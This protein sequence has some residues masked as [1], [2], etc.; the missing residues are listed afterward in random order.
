MPTFALPYGRTTLTCVVPERFR[1]NLLTLAPTPAAADP[2]QAVTDA[3]DRLLGAVR[4]DDFAGARTAAVA[5]N[6]KTRP[7]PHDHLLPPLLA[8]LEALGLPPE[9]ITLLIATGT[10]PPMAPDTFHTILPP[11]VLARYPVICHDCDDQAEL[12]HLG[13]TA[14]GTPVRINRRFAAADVRVVVG[15]IEPHQFQGFSGGVKSAAIGLAGRATVNHNHALMTDAQAR[16][17]QF[18]GNPARQ[19]VEE[20]GRIIHIHLALNAVLNDHKAVVHA[21]A[22]DPAAVL[23]AGIPLAQAICQVAV[24]APYDVV[25][26]SPGG[27]PKDINVYQAQKALAHAALITRPGGSVIL[28]AACPEGSGS[29]GYEQWVSGC[30]SQADVLDRFAREG[31][32][33]GPHKAYQ[34]AR[35]AARVTLRLVS[36]MPPDLARALLLPLAADLQSAVDAAL[37]PLPDS[38]RIAVMPRANA[39]IPLLTR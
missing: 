1:P 12:V 20:I 31:F 23:A 39:T 22:G 18:D 32:R 34:I 33:V 2:Q 26:A 24:D 6:D 13:T 27:H 15:N 17:G 8:R 19:D 5:V 16:L 4:W 11:A 25:I 3:L 29:R 9:R 10:H 21:L 36:D 35:D 37:A 30:R 38:A 7:V 28:A 14:R